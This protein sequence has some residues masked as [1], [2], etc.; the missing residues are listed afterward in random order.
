M[1]LIRT[2]GAV[3]VDLRTRTL[4]PGKAVALLAYL[5]AA[6]TRSVPRKD[7]FRLLYS[8]DTPRDADAF[9]QLLASLRKL[10]PGVF[11]TTGDNVQLT[12]ELDSDRRQFLEA[13]QKGHDEAAVAL[14]NRE[15]FEDF[16][17]RGCEGFLSWAAEERARL[18]RRFERSAETVVRGHLHRADWTAAI[19]VAWSVAER[20]PNHAVSTRLVVETLTTAGRGA[21]I[22]TKLSELL[23]GPPNGTPANARH[24]GRLIDD[25]DRLARDSGLSDPTRPLIGRPRAFRTLIETWSTTRSAAGGALLIDGPTGIG[26]S[27]LLAN[28]ALRLRLDTPSVIRDAARVADDAQQL[29]LL[30]RLAAAVIALP[31]ALGASPPSYSTLRALSAIAPYT[32]GDDATTP[33][34]RAIDALVDGLRAAGEEAPVAVL[35]DDL[36]LADDTTIRIIAG[37]VARLHNARVLFVIASHDSLADRITVPARYQI[38]LG[39][40]DATDIGYLCT[41]AGVTKSVDALRSLHDETDGVPARVLPL[42]ATPAAPPVR[43]APIETTTPV[44]SS[45][46][47]APAGDRDA[48]RWRVVPLLLATAATILLAVRLVSSSETT[49]I[50]GPETLAVQNFTGNSMRTE[51]FRIGAPDRPNTEPATSVGSD[52]VRWRFDRVPERISMSPDGRS[53][54]VQI[55]SDS[56]N[57]MDIIGV[58]GDSTFTIATGDRDD[59]TPAWSP[60]GSMVAF[61]ANRWSPVGNEGCDIAVRDVASTDIW[62]VTEGPDCD[63][64]PVW[65]QAGTSLAFLRRLRERSDKTEIC[66]VP[67]LAAPPRC[68]AIDTA[69]VVQELLGWTSRT[70]VLISGHMND[71]SGI[72]RFDLESGELQ[73]LID[74]PSVVVASLSPTGTYVACWC[75]QTNARANAITV[76]EL[77]GRRRVLEVQASASSPFRH[78]AWFSPSTSRAAHRDSLRL[79]LIARDALVADEARTR[80]AQRDTAGMRPKP[81]AARGTGEL[82]ARPAI[83]YADPAATFA[84]ATHTRSDRLALD[85]PWSRIDGARWVSFGDPRPRASAALGGLDPAGDGSY[86]SGLYTRE[87]FAADSGITVEA[88][89]R[90]PVTRPVWQEILISLESEEFVRSIAGWNHRSGIWA[91]VNP[92]T[93]FSTGLKYPALEGRDRSS[94]FS[95]SARGAGRIVP[96]SASLGDG[97]DVLLTV[98]LRRDS[99]AVYAANGVRIASLRYVPPPS[100]RYHLLI[101]GHSVESDVRMRAVRVWAREAKATDLAELRVGTGSGR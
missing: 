30:H 21:E 73:P 47:A 1:V 66:T 32:T 46:T 36:H 38:A 85:E 27:R 76:I 24:L 55:E 11:V 88:V 89:V 59:A 101:M 16:T 97:H 18:R 20:F 80:L 95:I 56:T 96:V 17:D 77:N 67:N 3:R 44:T 6:P 84:L 51:L 5:S 37:T 93:F 22:R 82:A 68:T 41:A 29:A 54:A 45:L 74:G 79:A 14:Y 40:L 8:D 9:R 31:G 50:R 81:V 15:F 23:V 53:M 12:E 49:S 26:K 7:L 33:P 91:A 61:S 57:N 65:S 64:T 4:G 13:A 39:P 35:L 75:S 78:L 92:N 52:S 94:A 90:V 10:L 62:R 42:L 99:T 58:R 86:P 2:F 63:V 19:A 48:R 34:A 72:Y 87:S 25:V 100:G 98:T 69:F 71:N 60:D 43:T 28:M 70:S 83:P